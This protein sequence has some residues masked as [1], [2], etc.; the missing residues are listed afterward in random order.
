[1]ERNCVRSSLGAPVDLV[2]V[3]ILDLDAEPFEPSAMRLERRPEVEL[4]LIGSRRAGVAVDDVAAAAPPHK[5]LEAFET[6]IG[7]VIRQVGVISPLAS[8]VERGDDHR[9]ERGAE[10]ER[11]SDISPVAH[12]RNRSSQ[13][14]VA[15]AG[16]QSRRGLI[17]LVRR[18]RNQV[19]PH[20]SLVEIVDADAQARL[21]LAAA[22]RQQIVDLDIGGVER[23]LDP[24]VRKPVVP[25]RGAPAQAGD[26]DPFVQLD[27]EP[28]A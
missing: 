17:G 16:D 22:K 6:E 23:I 28:L 2:Q 3:D 8:L 11:L 9:G 24:I 19:R 21:P 15:V 18:A 5:R 27:A 25:R 26:E 12:A 20:A 7:E 10:A 1:M 13:H 14:E 4:P